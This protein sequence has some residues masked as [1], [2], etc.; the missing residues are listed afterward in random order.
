MIKYPGRQA[1]RLQQALLEKIIQKGNEKVIVHHISEDT[2]YLLQLEVERRWP[3]GK[4]TFERF[5]MQ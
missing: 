1:S 5:R 4:I 2:P 3:C